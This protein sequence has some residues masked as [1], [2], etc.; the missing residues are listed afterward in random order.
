MVGCLIVWV[1][2]LRWFQRRN[3]Q[4]NNTKMRKLRIEP[5][6]SELQ[7]INSTTAP[8]IFVYYA[9]IKLKPDV[10]V[11]Y[12]HRT[13]PTHSFCHHEKTHSLLFQENNCCYYKI[14]TK[15]SCELEVTIPKNKLHEQITWPTNNLITHTSTISDCFQIRDTECIQNVC[16]MGVT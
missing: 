8:G 10:L 11:H 15:I 1:D 7:G 12:V 6:S 3:S 4:E 5:R 16:L 2:V 14:R 13:I 9:L